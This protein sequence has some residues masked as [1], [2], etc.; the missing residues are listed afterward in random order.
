M[1]KINVWENIEFSDK[2]AKSAYDYLVEQKDGLYQQT[3]GELRMEIDAIDTFLDT[4]PTITPAA[5]YI[6]YIIAPRLGNFRRK[7]I[8]VIEYS[9]SGRFPVDIFNHM[10][11]R[12]KRTNISEESFLNEFINLLGTHSIKSSIQNLFQQS[13][14]NGRTI[15]LNILSPNHAGVLV[16][17]DGSTINYGVKE[18]REDN[19]VYYTASALRL[20]AD[21]KDIEITSKKEDELLA[22][23]LL[24][25]IP[26]TSI[27]KV[28]S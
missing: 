4:K 18:I 25:I 8:S 1:A 14:E 16:L 28:L 2:K 23:G 24:N 21:K 6:V 20:F 3:G 17:R 27:L 10:D 7:I 15:G 5:L 13:K 11:E 22:L 9:D 12:D 19:L 26:L